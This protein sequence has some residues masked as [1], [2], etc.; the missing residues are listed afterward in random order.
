[1]YECCL[2]WDRL[3]SFCQSVFPEVSGEEHTKL[4]SATSSSLGECVQVDFSC[5]FRLEVSH[6]YLTSAEKR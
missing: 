1:M 2:G 5:V 3:T 4:N 6:V